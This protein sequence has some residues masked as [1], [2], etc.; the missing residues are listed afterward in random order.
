M[1]LFRRILFSAL[2]VTMFS[3]CSSD[4]DGGGM[5]WD[6]C[7][8]T[9]TLR[10]TDMYGNNLLDSL[11]NSCVIPE[12]SIDYDGKNYPVINLGD[13]YSAYT[14]A[15]TRFYMPCFSGLVL[16]TYEVAPQAGYLVFGEFDG[17]RDTELC[18]FTLKFRS[19]EKARLAYKNKVRYASNGEPKITRTFYFNGQQLTDDH[20]RSGIYNLI[21]HPFVSGSS[22]E[23]VPKEFLY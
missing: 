1:K 20:G 2:A 23:Y 22:L 5:I 11:S 21:Y 13:V 3:A 18:E 19:G 8:I 17:A 7:P 15:K 16:H 6:V 10:I 4:D 9:I 14:G 12:V